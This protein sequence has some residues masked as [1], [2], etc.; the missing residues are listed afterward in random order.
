MTDDIIIYVGGVGAGASIG[1][2]GR[3]V[4][5]GK[6]GY[7]PAISFMMTPMEDYETAIAAVNEVAESLLDEAIV[8]VKQLREQV[9]AW[10]EELEEEYT[11]DEDEDDYIDD[12]GDYVPQVWWRYYT[13]SDGIVCDHCLPLHGTIYQPL[14]GEYMFKVD[15]YDVTDDIVMAHNQNCRGGAEACRC[16]L[17]REYD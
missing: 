5:K 6:R 3:T 8:K 15:L 7:D 16:Y 17:Q 12:I 13:M 9:I 1:R 11:Y 4:P 10:N 14:Y 2:T